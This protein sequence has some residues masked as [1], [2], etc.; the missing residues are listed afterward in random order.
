MAKKPIKTESKYK[1]VKDITIP[2]DTDS[3]GRRHPNMSLLDTVIAETI[4]DPKYFRIEGIK[5]SESEYSVRIYG[6]RKK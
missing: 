1:F 2:I 6:S 4:Q 3:A 5:T